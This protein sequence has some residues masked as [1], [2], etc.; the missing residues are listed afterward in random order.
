VNPQTAMLKI[1][2]VFES[3]PNFAQ[4]PGLVAGWSIPGTEAVARW[5]VPLS[6]SGEEYHRWCDAFGHDVGASVQWS[7]LGTRAS[8]T[9]STIGE[10]EL[11]PP[12]GYV[13]RHSAT[14]VSTTLTHLTA[15][16]VEFIIAVSD[17]YRH[18]QL[19]GA[20]QPAQI[21]GPV[22]R[23]VTDTQAQLYPY[24][25]LACLLSFTK[26]ENRHFPIAIW[27]RD[28]SW[29]LAAPL[30]SDSWF[31]S[32]SAYAYQCLEKSG[33]EVYPISRGDFCPAEGD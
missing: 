8:S 3:M 19:P 27:P 1:G 29:S 32:G 17:I 15:K 10:D 25:T 13:D 7:K 26:E 28:L 9:S 6:N 20:H 33:L 4:N 21:I 14:I 5:L 24:D 23:F 31:F 16:N 2:E 22:P 11:W 30:Y 12:E 18:D